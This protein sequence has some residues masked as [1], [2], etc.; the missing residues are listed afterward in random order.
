M[1]AT[2]L[3]ADGGQAIR[4]LLAAAG[5]LPLAWLVAVAGATLCL[6]CL[7][8]RRFGGSGRARLRRGWATRREARRSELFAREGIILGRWGR[9]GPLIRSG[10]STHVFLAAATRSGKGAGFVIP[11]LL[12]WPGSVVAFDVK[13]ENH[14]ATAGF[15]AAHG[16]EVFL[17]DPESPDSDRWNPLRRIASDP[18]LRSRDLQRLA[19]ILYPERT[20]AEAFWTHQARELFVGAA[21]LA[22]ETR[23]SEATLGQVQ[24]FLSGPDLAGAV[25]AEL[26]PDA[27]ASAGVSEDCARRLLRWAESG[28][29]GMRAGI[30]ATACERLL[31]WSEPL[32]DRATSGRDFAP[33]ELRRRRLAVYIRVAP[34]A[35]DRLAPVLRLFVEDLVHANTASPFGADHG[36]PVPVLLMLDEFPL[37]GR[38]GSVERA[39]AYVASYGLR[40][41]IVAQSE[42]QLRGVYGEDGAQT[43]IRNCA[44][45]VYHAPETAEDA[46]ALS[47]ALGSVLAPQRTRSHP[48]GLLSRSGA[49]VSVTRAERPLLRPQ[50]AR[51]MPRD[52]SVV[53]VPGCRPI[54]STKIRWW[55]DPEFSRRSRPRAESRTSRS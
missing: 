27:G 34:G 7:R 3:A 51:A 21:Q 33:D 49:S 29:E 48:S 26:G 52:A 37:L 31:L 35:I 5:S 19:A 2:A 8:S 18:G 10:G 38:A 42:T 22:L 14:A 54:R 20:A 44:A 46:N 39:I 11:N 17:F 47:N 45:R 28:S 53:L 1:Q 41:C 25:A 50:D 40:C 32:L 30:L 6:A 13:G 15:R 24:R 43:L 12:D 23:G 36:N 9:R 55:R 16:H 4:S